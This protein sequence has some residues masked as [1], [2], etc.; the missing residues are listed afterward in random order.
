MVAIANLLEVPLRYMLEERTSRTSARRTLPLRPT[1]RWQLSV[2]SPNRNQHRY[3]S[4][5]AKT[6]QKPYAR[7]D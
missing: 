2:N 6:L 7:G 1:A 5:H 3:G 4:H